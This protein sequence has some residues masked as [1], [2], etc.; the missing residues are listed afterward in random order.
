[1][2]IRAPSSSGTSK[3]MLRRGNFERHRGAPRPIFSRRPLVSNQSIRRFMGR[4][5]PRSTLDSRRKSGLCVPA[6]GVSP[7]EVS[8]GVTAS[9]HARRFARKIRRCCRAAAAMPTIL[10]VP[11]GTLHAHVIRSPHPHA[12]IVKIDAADGAGK[13][14][15]LGGHHRRGRHEDLRSV[16]GR[17]EIAHPPMVARG[18]SRA[19]CRRAGGAGGGG[20]PLSRRGRRRA[21]RASNT[22]RW[23]R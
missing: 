8:F 16:P 5:V 20:E 11:A 7:R 23:K 2:R 21:G 3:V 14:R 10:P 17:A 15:R 6:F 12:D 4:P 19:L 18:R 9:R 13:G 22:R 1:M